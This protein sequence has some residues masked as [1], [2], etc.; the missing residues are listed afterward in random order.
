[1]KKFIITQKQAQEIYSFISKVNVNGKAVHEVSRCMIILEN[2]KL[3]KEEKPAP[4][5]SEQ[6]LEETQ[7]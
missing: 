2:L 1:M 6:K 5:Q 3:I 4:K 7:K